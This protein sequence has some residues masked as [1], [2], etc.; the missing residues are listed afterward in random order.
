MGADGVKTTEGFLRG[1]F[2]KQYPT[3]AVDWVI[4]ENLNFPREYAAHAS[5]SITPPTIGETSFRQSISQLWLSGA[6]PVSFPFRS[7]KLIGERV[8]LI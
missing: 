8:S 1:M 6:K 5:C 2:T 4:Q 7:T 3:D